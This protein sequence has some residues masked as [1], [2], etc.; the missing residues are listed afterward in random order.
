VSGLSF[1]F[2]PKWS[3]SL[4]T[5]HDAYY[6]ILS[7]QLRPLLDMCLDI[8]GH[9]SSTVPVGRPDGGQPQLRKGL[10]NRHPIA[11]FNS[12]HPPQL[13]GVGKDFRSHATWNEATTFFICPHD[14]F[15]WTK[16]MNAGFN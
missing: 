9:L 13:T 12:Q 15:Y 11:V 14:N 7:F 4:N 2:D 16:C 6:L 3:S 1:Y 8:C 10:A 5:F